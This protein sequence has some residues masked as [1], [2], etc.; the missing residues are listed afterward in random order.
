ML[1]QAAAKLVAGRGEGALKEL[2][3]A[4]PDA[5][6]ARNVPR[7]RNQRTT[8]GGRQNQLRVGCR[9]ITGWA[10]SMPR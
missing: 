6:A 8:A 7:L 9:G 10:G 2:L 5:E 1:D 4:G 3:S